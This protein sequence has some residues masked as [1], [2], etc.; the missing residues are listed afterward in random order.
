MRSRSWYVGATVGLLAGLLVSI[1]MTIADWRLNPTG[2]FHD[3]TG[4][5]WAI[6]AETAYSWFAPVAL[7]V[8]VAAVA[9]HSWLS[10]TRKD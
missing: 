2:I 4:T 10:R 3:D 7:V 8:F 9:C 6:V 1:P 5:N